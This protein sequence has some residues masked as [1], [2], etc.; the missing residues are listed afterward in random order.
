MTWCELFV[1][2]LAR[3]VLPYLDDKVKWD[4]A[5]DMVPS[6]EIILIQHLP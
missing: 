6:L 3:W 4:E 2:L 1:P 5:W